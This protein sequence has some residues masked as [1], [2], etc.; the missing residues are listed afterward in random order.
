LKNNSIDTYN[1]EVVKMKKVNNTH[2][3]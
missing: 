3:V 2:V 1:N